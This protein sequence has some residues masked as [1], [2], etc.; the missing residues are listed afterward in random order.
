MS[1]GACNFYNKVDIDRI[2]D[3]YTRLHYALFTEGDYNLNIFGIRS[4]DMTSNQFNDLV[5]VVYRYKNNWQLVKYG[6]TTDPGL[7][8]RENPMNV[9]GTAIVAPGQYRSVFKIGY[10]QGKYRAL[11]QNKPILLYR[12]ADRDK[13]NEYIGEPKWEIAGINLHRANANIPSKLVSQWSAGCIT[14][15]DPVDFDE[16]MTLV[17]IS[18][19]RYGN[20]FTFTL[21]TED[22]I[23]SN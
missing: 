10:H 11:V 2:L 9:N 18:A 14:I 19:K 6:A 1:S 17:D 16:F 12:D 20:T 5:G 22:Q 3:A 15:A 21:F 7:Y 8:Y 13:V 23:F 4:N